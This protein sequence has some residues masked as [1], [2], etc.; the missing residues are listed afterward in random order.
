MRGKGGVSYLHPWSGI[1][2]RGHI[3]TRSFGLIVSARGTGKERQSNASINICIPST[4]QSTAVDLQRINQQPWTF[5]ASINICG[6][7][8]H[9]LAHCPPDLNLASSEFEAAVYSAFELAALKN[10]R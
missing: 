8:T 5:N 6:P 2:A 7:S 3:L 4:H 9:Q 1:V 10:N